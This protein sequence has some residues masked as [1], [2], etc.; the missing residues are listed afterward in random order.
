MDNFEIPIMIFLNTAWMKHYRGIT[1]DDRPMHGGEYVNENE[2]GSEILNFLPFN[3][4]LYGYVQPPR[5]GGSN[6]RGVIKIERLGAGWLDDNISGILVVWVARSDALGSVIV[7]WYK[8]ATVYRAVQAPPASSN[9]LYEGDEIEYYVKTKEKNGILLPVK[10]R[11]FQ[12]PRG[13]GWMGQAN[14]WYAD[15]EDNRIFRSKVANYID[16]YSSVIKQP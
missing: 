1:S 10:E 4:D 11:I 7:G 16:E 12:I 2:S 15:Q 9:R 3:G 14:T 13:R 8:D 5:G 6:P